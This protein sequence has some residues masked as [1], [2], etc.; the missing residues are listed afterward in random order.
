MSQILSNIGF[1]MMSFFFG[2]RDLFVPPTK[3]ALEAGIRPG[4]RVLDYGCGTGSHALAAAELAGEKGRV[5]ALDIHPLAVRKVEKAAARRGLKNT[6]TILSGCATGLADDSVDVVLLYDVFHSISDPESALKELRRVLRPG[7]L[8][9]FS[10]HHMEEE[11]IL[12]RMTDGRYFKL[13]GRGKRTYAF[14]P[15]NRRS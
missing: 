14:S 2:I 3:K 15:E 11:A 7:G 9:S 4:D 1:R 6:T 13:S 10:D 5:H 8:L 12:S